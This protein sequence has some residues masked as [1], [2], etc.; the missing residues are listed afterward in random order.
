[1]KL[2]LKNCAYK[3]NILSEEG[4]AIKLTFQSQKQL[5]REN[6]EFDNKNNVLI[7]HIKWSKTIQYGERKLK[8]PVTAILIIVLNR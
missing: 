5:I 6:I 3:D 1:L 2:L 4:R 7:F 8:I